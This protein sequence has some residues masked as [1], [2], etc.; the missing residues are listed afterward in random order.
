MHTRA[1]DA[2][3]QGRRCVQPCG[4]ELKMWMGKYTKQQEDACVRDEDLQRAVQVSCA[5]ELCRCQRPRLPCRDG[6]RQTT[7]EDKSE[8]EQDEQAIQ[9]ERD[10]SSIRSTQ[11]DDARTMCRGRGGAAYHRMGFEN[12]DGKGD[13]AAGRCLWAGRGAVQVSCAVEM[14]RCQRPR[15]PWRRIRGKSDSLV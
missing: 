4:W 10:A 11:A 13:E 8:G 15:L 9:R 3:G 7:D 14:C 12:V 2:Q 1:E 5:V 6:I